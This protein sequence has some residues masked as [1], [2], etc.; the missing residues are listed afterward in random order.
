MAGRK[1][2]NAKNCASLEAHVVWQGDRLAG[3]QSNVLGG[4][5]E[6]AL[7]LAVPRPDALADSVI[8]D[9][10]AHGLDHACAVTVRNDLGERWPG[11]ARASACTHLDVGRV[12]S[13]RVEP[14]QHFAARRRGIGNVLK[15]QHVARRAESFVSD[16]A[17]V[18]LQGRS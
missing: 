5:S 12:G 13:G 2:G 16:C 4:R 3:G 1:T 7:P 8:G 6:G 10:I 14:D 17:H 11:H 15:C 9:V 18:F